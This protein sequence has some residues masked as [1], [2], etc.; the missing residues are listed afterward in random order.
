MKNKMLRN[1][2]KSCVLRYTTAITSNYIIIY[3]VSRKE[4]LNLITSKIIYITLIK[5][6]ILEIKTV[7][8]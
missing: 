2:E 4:A 6:I 5:A 7:V 1:E 8:I 3:L